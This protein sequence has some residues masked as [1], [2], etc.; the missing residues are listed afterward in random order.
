VRNA[1][2]LVIGALALP[3]CVSQEDVRK[4]FQEHVTVTGRVL[5]FA[6]DAQTEALETKLALVEADPKLEK[7]LGTAAEVRKRI[8]K[9]KLEQQA[10]T[11]ELKALKERYP[12]EESR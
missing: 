4:P 8:E 7:T 11:A 6:I 9:V 2:A 1:L 10:I 5:G 3:G 12:L